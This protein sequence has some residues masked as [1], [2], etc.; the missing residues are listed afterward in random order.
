MITPD[1]LHARFVA[2]CDKFGKSAIG[3]LIEVSPSRVTSLYDG[4][5]KMGKETAE[6]YGYTMHTMFEQ[7]EEVKSGK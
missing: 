7:F 5:A 3:R 1:E 2:D 4:S 6:R